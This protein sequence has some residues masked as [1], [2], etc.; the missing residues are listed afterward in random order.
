[1]SD[2]PAALF[3]DGLERPLVLLVGGATGTG[4][5][6]VATEVAHRLGITRVTS[7]DFIR[8]TIRAFFPP[9]VMPSVHYSSFEGEPP[10]RCFLEQTE[11]VLIGVGAV[12][13]RAL[14]EAW[15]IVLEGVHLVPGLVPEQIEGAIVVQAMLRVESEEVH[16]ARFHV[17]DASTGGTRAMEKYVQR[18]GAIRKIQEYIVDEAERAGVPVI[19]GTN[20]ERAIAE[21]MELVLSR[22]ELGVAV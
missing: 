12:L 5:S 7:T 1:M 9:A 15:S 18:L 16:R 8:Q 10:I 6:T 17:R 22:A 19:E 3:P 4:K 20:R 14:A 13:G 11:Q 21:L 2:L